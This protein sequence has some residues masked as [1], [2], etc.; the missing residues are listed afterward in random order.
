MEAELKE[1][2][3]TKRKTKRRKKEPTAEKKNTKTC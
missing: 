3:R 1:M 2:R